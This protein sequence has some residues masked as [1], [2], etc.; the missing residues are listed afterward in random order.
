MKI[1]R[2]IAYFSFKLF[3]GYFASRNHKSYAVMTP[4]KV[5]IDICPDVF[6]YIVKAKKCS[7]RQYVLL[8]S[9]IRQPR[10]IV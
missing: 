2:I 4:G 3:Y 6:L 7:C 1:L 9:P 10:C 8:T 5:Q